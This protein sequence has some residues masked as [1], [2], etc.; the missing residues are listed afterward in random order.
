MKSIVA[1]FG[2]TQCALNETRYPACGHA[3]YVNNDNIGLWYWFE[4]V[5]YD[6]QHILSGFVRDPF[7]ANRLID[8]LLGASPTF[9]YRFYS[10][11]RSETRYLNTT[12]PPT[13]P[14]IAQSK[15]FDCL[16]PFLLLPSINEYSVVLLSEGHRLLLLR[17]CFS[18]D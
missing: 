15:T 2:F 1:L 13:H 6:T 7:T 18:F 9:T 3:V 4:D 16:A 11:Y 17:M 14:Q 12:H 10:A 8:I 5:K